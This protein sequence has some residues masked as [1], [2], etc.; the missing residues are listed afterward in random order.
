MFE[1]A[2]K[3]F[4]YVTLQNKLNMSISYN[5]INTLYKLNLYIILLNMDLKFVHI[6]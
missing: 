2:K 6:L 1:T 4:T 3:N 5:S